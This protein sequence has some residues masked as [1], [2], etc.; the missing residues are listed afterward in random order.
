MSWTSEERA[1]S[2]DTGTTAARTG[3]ERG[4]GHV[5]GNRSPA[6]RGSVSGA[7]GEVGPTSSAL[8]QLAGDVEGDTTIVDHFVTDYLSLL[9]SRI[10]RLPVLLAAG[11]HESLFVLMLSLEST[12]AMIGAGDVVRAARAVRTALAG[13]HDRIGPALDELRSALSGIR[14]ALN[15][16]GFRART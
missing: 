11:D 15:D 10:E 2:A 5:S 4:T 13:P 9:D 7:L 1:G 16:L 3:G 6:V 8:R 12:S 14:T